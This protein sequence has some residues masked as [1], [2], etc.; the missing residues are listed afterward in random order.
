MV[1]H[2]SETVLDLANE[3]LH[4]GRPQRVL[5]V[6]MGG[7]RPAE[8]GATARR[9]GAP[10]DLAADLLTLLAHPNIAS[11]ADVIR[12]YDHEVQGGTVI[13]PLTGA[14]NDGPSD[15]CVIKPAGTAGRRGIVLSNGINPEF[16]KRDPYRMAVSVVDEAVRNAVAVGADPDR[17]ALL[18]NFCWGDVRRP[19]T[20]GSLVSAARGCHDAALHHGAPFISGKDSLNNEYLGADGRR[21]AIA[22]TLL[23]SAIGVIEDV[24]RAVTMDLKEVGDL[25][26]LAGET[27][28]ELGGS[29]LELAGGTLGRTAAGLGSVPGQAPQAPALYRALHQA[30]LMGVVRAAHDLSEG[31]LAVAAAEMSIGGRL[32][33]ALELADEDPVTALFSE[34]NG[35]LLVEVRPA[36]EAAF[37][38]CFAGRPGLVPRRVGTVTAGARLE[39]SAGARRLVSLAVADLVAAWTR[40]P[41]VS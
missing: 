30:M 7:P 10:A 11:K 31:G 6:T 17:L 5:A 34:S 37:E 35:R 12:R 38:A 4:H 16:G 23:I 32:G 2:G 28:P 27:R 33:L 39:I 24:S 36:D 18:D 8:A 25:L 13:K 19:E 14:A 3:F 29:H 9:P 40:G 22:P 1:R 41:A 15:A 20:L 26:Y 21:H